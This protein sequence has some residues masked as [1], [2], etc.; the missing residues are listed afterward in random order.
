[1][2]SWRPGNPGIETLIPDTFFPEI[3]HSPTLIFTIP[4]QP[5]NV[6]RR[7]LLMMTPDVLRTLPHLAKHHTTVHVAGT[8][9]ALTRSNPCDGTTE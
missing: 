7:E 2:A 3:G 1:M 9:L 8:T 5:F 6:S 4:P